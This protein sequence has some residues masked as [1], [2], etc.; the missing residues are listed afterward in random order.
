MG[1]DVLIRIPR[2][3]KSSKSSIVSSSSSGR[4]FSSQSSSGSGED[5]SE[6]E[7]SIVRYSP[8]PSTKSF[9]SQKSWKAVTTYKGNNNVIQT[10]QKSIIGENLLFEGPFGKRRCKFASKN[11]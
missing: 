1:L 11:H 5:N 9:H 3:R 7:M 2:S 8:P 10:L 6:G 4:S